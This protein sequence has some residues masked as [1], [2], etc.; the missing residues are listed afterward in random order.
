[1]EKR[2]CRKFHHGSP[3]KRSRQLWYL[4]LKSPKQFGCIDKK[5]VLRNILKFIMEFSMFSHSKLNLNRL[6]SME[7]KFYR[8]F[9]LGP[10]N[11]GHR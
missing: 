2:F 9:P 7:K 5:Y 6:L 3:N 11:K 10:P 4:A 1:M 8:K